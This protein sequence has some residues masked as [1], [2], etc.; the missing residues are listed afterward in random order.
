MSDGMPSL[1]A[2]LELVHDTPPNQAQ[3]PEGNAAAVI[4]RTI[5][6]ASTRV[7]IEAI[8]SAPLSWAH[9]LEAIVDAS[10][11]HDDRVATAALS[12][13]T[14][15]GGEEREAALVALRKLAAGDGLAADAAK[16]ALV[17]AN[18][19]QVVP[20]LAAGASSASARERAS[21][22]ERYARLGQVRQALG[23]VADRDVTVRARAACAILAIDD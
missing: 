4:E 15:L 17:D 1:V 3:T 2:A 22:A 18:D 11:A 8:L 23:F 14:S 12:R 7:R 16:Q 9:L 6:G 20:L 21:T 10:E 19:A 13:M 5:D